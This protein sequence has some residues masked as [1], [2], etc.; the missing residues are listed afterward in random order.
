MLVL[1]TR[2]ALPLR[3]GNEVLMV[4][5]PLAW[6][7]VWRINQTWVP[8][9]MTGQRYRTFMRRWVLESIFVPFFWLRKVT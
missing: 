6:G 3:Q 1:V 5:E 4:V 7:T 2:Q 9:R 8:Y